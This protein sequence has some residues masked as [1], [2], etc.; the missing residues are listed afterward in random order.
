MDF[1][2]RWSVGTGLA[3]MLIVGWIGISESKYHAWRHRYGKAN[4]HN[5]WAPRDWWLLDWEKEAIIRFAGEYPLEG[6][7]RLTYMMLDRE[8]VCA[9]PTT[10]YRTLRDAG[11]L[12]RWATSRSKK[13]SGFEQPQGPHAHWHVDVLYVNL[14]GTFYY[15]LSVLDG[16]S[17]Y[18]V[19]WDIRESMT[20]GD[21]EIVLQGAK[22]A[23]PFARPRIIS[24]NGGQF[25][26]KE[27]KQFIRIS[28][29]THVRTSPGYP[30]SNGKIERWH[31]S[32]KSECIRVKT[33]LTLEDA[34]RVLGEY[35]EHYNNVRLHSGIGYITP[36]DKLEGR[37]AEIFAER[38]RRL[39]EARAMRKAR[40]QQAGI[41][42]ALADGVRSDVGEAETKPP[43][44]KV[45]DLLPHKEIVAQCD[46]RVPTD[47]AVGTL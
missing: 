2:R 47:V 4:E 32:V 46:R 11:M 22:E 37:E 45:S 5:G 21:V 6:Y 7:R 30:Q 10:V 1:V 40:R 25:V 14:H 23:F 38:D 17:R 39:E 8:I 19:Q 44:R 15:L 34:R 42:E 35:V 13:G 28:G 3:A 26:A 9:S 27:F 31:C 33:P 12:R 36:K 41:A 18:I 20:E 43:S 16:W 29:M 24:D